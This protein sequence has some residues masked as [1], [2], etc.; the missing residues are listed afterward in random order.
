[1]RSD[2]LTDVA[3]GALLTRI[4]L[5]RE[6][7]STAYLEQLQRAWCFA[8]PFHNLDLLAAAAT[9]GEP[10]GPGAA[11]ERCIDGLGGPCHV[12]SYGFLS[13]LVTLGFDA[14]LCGAAVSHPDD[15][16]VIR[17][18]I[19][20]K[21]YF[22]D[23]GNGQPYLQ[24]FP[25]DGNLRQEHLGWVVV[26]RPVEAGIVVERSSPDQPASR[27]V[28]RASKAPLRWE[29]FERTIHRHHAERGFGPF[30]TGVRAVRMGPHEMTTVRDQVLTRYRGTAFERTILNRH[31]LERAL[32]EEL[33][34]GALPIDDALRGLAP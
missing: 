16:L 28:Y 32:R 22:C 29:D 14:H 19:D 26:S 5:V 6:R 9:G 12:Q 20:D 10:L 3:R 1:M 24:P 11:I 8:Q 25:E 7:P 33:G 4:D 17:V 2:P 18:V 13:L 27:Q 21:A 30:L 34:L 23:V 15:H 31:T